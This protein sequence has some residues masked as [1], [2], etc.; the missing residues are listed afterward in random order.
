MFG[1]DSPF[2]S[3]QTMRI[4]NAPDER[5]WI[6]ILP[7]TFKREEGS[8][9][10]TVDLKFMNQHELLRYEFPETYEKF[11]SK[12]FDP[13]VVAVIFLAMGHGLDIK[14]RGAVTATL[15]ENLMVFQQIWHKWDPERYKMINILPESVV[16]SIL[17]REEHVAMMFS[18]GLDSCYTVWKHTLA[19]STY[20]KKKLRSALFVLGF[21]IPSKD[22]RFFD[23]YY[24]K[25]KEITDSVQIDL[26]PVHFNFR[27]IIGDWSQSH[28][29]ALASCLHL[30]SGLFS[31][32]LISSSH[33][34]DALR[35]PWGSNPLTD[36]LLSSDCLRIIN[37]GGEC[38]RWEKAQAVA[39][40]PLAMSHLRVC[41]DCKERDRNCG[42]CDNCLQTALSFAAAGKVPPSVLNVSGI[43]DV[44]RQFYVHSHNAVG[45]VRLEQLIA[46]ARQQGNDGPWLAELEDCCRFHKKRL[47][48]IKPLSKLMLWGY[49]FWPK[50]A[51]F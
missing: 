5:A 14:V 11:L 40:W 13:Y 3:R 1:I 50:K 32:G 10:V 2:N 48:L 17:P 31:S 36:P 39:D 51:V 24:T 43:D 27:K 30:F 12:T 28:G 16:E 46:Y 8:V 6:E 37:D 7:P 9:L 33:A 26:I 23:S 38:A 18:G 45:V 47:R 19:N 20:P 35:L 34:Y 4:L 22:A 29:S 15:L 44:V 41:Y 49:K 21:D 42:V 25:A